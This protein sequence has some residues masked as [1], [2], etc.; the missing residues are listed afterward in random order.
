MAAHNE[1][2]K[3]GGELAAK[4]L[5]EKGYKILERN[6]RLGDLEVDI[7]AR[8]G[9]FVVFVEV[10]TRTDDAWMN[11][12]QA[13]DKKRKIRMSHAAKAYMRGH[14]ITDLEVRYDIV[15][16]VLNDTRCDIEHFED[17]FIPPLRTYGRYG[18][19]YS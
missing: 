11:P 18:V 6:W 17:A 12:A 13:V 16:I 1:L 5:R 15:S 14:K 10:K 19:M 4:M 7:I 9:K 8:K 3:R 2:G